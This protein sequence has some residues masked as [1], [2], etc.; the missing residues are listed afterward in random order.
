MIEIQ[1]FESK[2]SENNTKYSD[3]EKTIDDLNRKLR[4]KDAGL[5]HLN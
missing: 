4:D 1:A 3:Y 2:Y 5:N